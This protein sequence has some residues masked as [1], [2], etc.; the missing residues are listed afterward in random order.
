[1]GILISF[2]IMYQP[3]KKL[4]GEQLKQ[5]KNISLEIMNI[6]TAEREMPKTKVEE[7]D[8]KAGGVNHD[9]ASGSGHDHQKKPAKKK[10]Y[11]RHSPR[12]IQEMEA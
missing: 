5:P 8:S 1:M 2:Q 3:K 4:E 11:H 12:Q 9:G 10:R 7:I 6:T